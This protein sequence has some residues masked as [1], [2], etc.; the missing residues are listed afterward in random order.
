MEDSNYGADYRRD[1]VRTV[2]YR[3]LDRAA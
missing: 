3:A 1:L 2:T